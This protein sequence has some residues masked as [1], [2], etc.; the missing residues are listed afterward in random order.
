MAGRERQ[1]GIA[2][3]L[4]RW[5]RRHMGGAQA[6]SI[7]T[8]ASCGLVGTGWSSGHQ[9]QGRLLALLWRLLCRTSSDVRDGM[10]SDAN[11]QWNTSPLPRRKQKAQIRLLFAARPRVTFWVVNGLLQE[12]IHLLDRPRLKRCLSPREKLHEVGHYTYS[13]RQHPLKNPM[14]AGTAPQKGRTH[15][16]MSRKNTPWLWREHLES[17]LQAKETAQDSGRKETSSIQEALLK[18][19]FL[20]HS[21]SFE[22]H[23]TCSS[24]WKATDS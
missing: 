17:C 14:N 4:T 13:C 21:S 20:K 6:S 5:C 23:T 19:K 7:L 24:G 12:R 2:Q 22:H 10:R 11:R 15:P 1:A 8:V 16:T 3:H 9:S 18:L